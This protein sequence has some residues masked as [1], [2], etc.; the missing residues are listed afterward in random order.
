M[1]PKFAF[2][3]ASSNAVTQYMSEEILQHVI[4]IIGKRKGTQFSL[5]VD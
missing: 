1:S 5:A 2:F 3:A 4:G